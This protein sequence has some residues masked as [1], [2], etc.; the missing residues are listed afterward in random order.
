MDLIAP[1]GTIPNYGI[2]AYFSMA[3]D[4]LSVIQH[5]GSD[6]PAWVRGVIARTDEAYFRKGGVDSVITDIENIDFE[7]SLHLYEQIKIA[8]ATHSAV[9]QRSFLF[10]LHNNFPIESCFR[11]FERISG[12]GFRSPVEK[13][14]IVVILL[15]YLERRLPA[16]ELKPLVDAMKEELECCRIGC[17]ENLGALNTFL[18]AVPTEKPIQGVR[19]E[20]DEG[21]DGQGNH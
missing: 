14:Q 2:E 11:I 8:L 9:L 10:A 15:Q 4:W 12:A 21:A 1:I 20:P 6:V 5:E 3:F 19:Q 7:V 13:A 16:H 18:N 17:E